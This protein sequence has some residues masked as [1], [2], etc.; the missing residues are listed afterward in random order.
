[1]ALLRLATCALRCASRRAGYSLFS[2]HAADIE[3]LLCPPASSFAAGSSIPLM[4]SLT[5]S[6]APSFIS[7]EPGLLWQTLS[8]RW[9]DTFESHYS[10]TSLSI[11]AYVFQNE[12]HMRPPSVWTQVLTPRTGVC[13]RI[14]FRHA[15]LVF[16]IAW[17]LRAW[18]A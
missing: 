5:A 4:P 15:E 16:H 2:N 17:Q 3:G 6:F 1:M 9:V 12:R 10:C 11:S 18:L 8:A 13:E 7:V 14:H